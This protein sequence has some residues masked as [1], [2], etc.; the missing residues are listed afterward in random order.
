MSN[1][2]GAFMT[3]LNLIHEPANFLTDK[4]H[5]LD[6]R[7]LLDS[8]QGAGFNLATEGKASL[9]MPISPVKS[10]K[11]WELFDAQIKMELL[12]KYDTK[13]SRYNARLG[14]EKHFLRLQSN[15]LKT[16]AKGHDLFLRVTNSYDG[17][18]S[19]R[20][21]LDILRLV[22]LNGMVAPRSIFEIA[23]SH[24]SKNIYVDAIEA[25][26]KILAKKDLID[27]QIDAM[28]SKILNQDEKLNLVDTMFN[29]RFPESELILSPS[30]KLELL[31]PKRIEENN[32]NLYQNFNTLQEKFT[33]GARV[34]LLDE[35]GNEIKRTVREVKSQVTADQFNDNSWNFAA[36]LAA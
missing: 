20:V 36:S 1:N 15:E 10:M 4:Y 14:H 13:M 3:N 2:K 17:S 8:F 27:N 26:Y 9:R 32:D 21:S 18:S 33:R 12:E 5:V 11:N 23:V 16:R 31:T 30:K 35:N 22:C 6:T 25:S 7:K 28:Q 24:R 29:F 19:L 34:T